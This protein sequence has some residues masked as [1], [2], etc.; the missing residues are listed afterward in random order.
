MKWKPQ[1][2]HLFL[3]C[4][5]PGSVFFATAQEIW[6]LSQFYILVIMSKFCLS[7]KV[8]TIYWF[9]ATAWMEMRLVWLI[10]PLWD[11]NLFLLSHELLIFLEIIPS[12][13]QKEKE[14]GAQIYWIIAKFIGNNFLLNKLHMCFTV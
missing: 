10:F 3:Q 7:F 13:V 14:N 1:C 11:Y 5:F 4:I 6:F 12:T 9:K 8:S 2:N